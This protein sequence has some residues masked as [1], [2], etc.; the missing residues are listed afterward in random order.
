MCY[1]FLCKFVYT[2]NNN[3]VILLLFFLNTNNVMLM[4]SFSCVMADVSGDVLGS[5]RVCSIWFG[6]NQFLLG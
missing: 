5:G 4:M 3:N 6:L 1:V 2:N